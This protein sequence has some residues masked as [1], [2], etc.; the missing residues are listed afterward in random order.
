MD[1]SPTPA[2]DP[3]AQL[4][5]RSKRCPADAEAARA[6]H[7]AVKGDAQRPTPLTP[8]GRE[9]ARTLRPW[10][11]LGRV[12]ECLCGSSLLIADEED[13]MAAAPNA[14]AEALAAAG[15]DAG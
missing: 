10:P 6:W 4:R 7:V 1:A 3:I 8:H 5:E 15:G 2:A 9:L 12:G 14:R 11:G 13:V